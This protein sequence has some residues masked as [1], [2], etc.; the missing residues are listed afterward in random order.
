MFYLPD[1]TVISSLISSVVTHLTLKH[2]LCILLSDTARCAC[3]PTA[4]RRAGC[5]RQGWGGCICVLVSA[6][7]SVLD[8]AF[9]AVVTYTCTS[10]CVCV[11]ECRYV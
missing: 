2:N 4:S 9:C 3:Q 8:G 5:G 6:D 7:V 1:E 11:Y 10:L